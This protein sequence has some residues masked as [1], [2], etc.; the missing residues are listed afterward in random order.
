MSLLKDTGFGPLT[1]DFI[2]Q[3]SYLRITVITLANKDLGLSITHQ[4][5]YA[6]VVVV[7][8]IQD[9]IF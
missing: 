5:I 3:V 2:V 4:K 1:R 8:V 9:Q 7:V 6:F